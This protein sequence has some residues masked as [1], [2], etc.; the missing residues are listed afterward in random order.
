MEIRSSALKVKRTQCG[1]SRWC[2]C[3]NILSPTDCIIDRLASYMYAETQ[4]HNLERIKK[5][6]ENESQ[7]EVYNEFIDALK[8]YGVN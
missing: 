2:R 3:I 6:C 4:P 7:P 5:W 1:A 8:K